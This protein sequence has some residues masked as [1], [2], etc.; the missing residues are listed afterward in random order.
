MSLINLCVEHLSPSRWRCL[1]TL[2]ESLRG[3]SSLEEAA[4]WRR[5]LRLY[6]PAPL[7]IHSLLLKC[8]HN[9]TSHL[10]ASATMLSLPNPLYH[11]GLYGLPIEINLSLL[12]CF[13]HGILSQQQESN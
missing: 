5:A 1:G 9:V 4:H 12:S 13:C 11:Y 2:L 10:P 6:S 8:G 7:P 3:W